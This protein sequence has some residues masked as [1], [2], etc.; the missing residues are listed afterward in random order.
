MENED[1][2]TIAQNATA[3]T[4]LSVLVVT[5]SPPGRLMVGTAYVYTRVYIKRWQWADW[6]VTASLRGYMARILPLS[7]YDADISSCSNRIGTD[8]SKL[9]FDSYNRISTSWFCGCIITAFLSI[10]R[11]HWELRCIIQWPFPANAPCKQV[12]MYLQF[13]AAHF[14]WD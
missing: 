11:K 13:W 5:V 4:G 9:Y 10:P 3:T 1:H 8:Q 7:N 6:A 2:V 14:F 12:H